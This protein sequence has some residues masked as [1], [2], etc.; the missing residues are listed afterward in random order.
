M[1]SPQTVVPH[2]VS[3]V[4]GGGNLLKD[5]KHKRADS[6]KH[7]KKKKT[8]EKKRKSRKSSDEEGSWQEATAGFFYH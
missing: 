8:K 4:V 6:R 3:G 5:R 7:K 2:I 1:H